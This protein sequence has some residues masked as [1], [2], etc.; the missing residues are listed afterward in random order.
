VK[1]AEIYM[2]LGLKQISVFLEALLAEFVCHS[3]SFEQARNAK[4]NIE[5]YVSTHAIVMEGVNRR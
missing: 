5:I 1:F 3:S 2:G 4:W